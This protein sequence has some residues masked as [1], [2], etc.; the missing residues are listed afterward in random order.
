MPV[1]ALLDR[2][3]AMLQATQYDTTCVDFGHASWNHGGVVPAHQAAAARD[4]KLQ[5]HLLPVCVGATSVQTTQLTT[6]L[7]LWPLTPQAVYHQEQACSLPS[8]PLL[9]HQATNGVPLDADHHH[10]SVLFLFLGFPLKSFKTTS[11]SQEFQDQD[12]EY[13][14]FKKKEDF[15]S[16]KAPF[17]EENEDTVFTK[18]KMKKGKNHPRAIV[19]APQRVSVLRMRSNVM[20][21]CSTKYIFSL[22][23]S[24]V[25]FAACSCPSSP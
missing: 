13:L 23:L 15:A 11:P 5:E 7:Q 14:F 20:F 24:F 22:L 16:I 8:V 2:S 3:P 18:K 9:L 6:L 25:W 21:Y 4:S 12:I 1:F 10:R 17:P 19:A